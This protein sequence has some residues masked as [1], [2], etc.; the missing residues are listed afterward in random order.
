MRRGPPG[1]ITRNLLRKVPG[2]IPLAA[3]SHRTY[4]LTVRSRSRSRSRSKI[5]IKV[6]IKI[7]VT[8]ENKGAQNG[9]WLRL[10]G[11]DADAWGWG[12]GMRDTTRDTWCLCG[13]CV[14]RVFTLA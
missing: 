13:A 2:L 10:E 14:S 12:R 5:K 7:N 6:K 1:R 4:V 9:F 11:R 8:D 3:L